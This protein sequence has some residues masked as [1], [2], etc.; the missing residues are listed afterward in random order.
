MKLDNTKQN[1]TFS[2]LYRCLIMI[3]AMTPEWASFISQRNSFKPC[4][5]AEQKVSA[6]N[7][8]ETNKRQRNSI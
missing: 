2:E 6:A 5:C 4:N 3:A 1:K 8:G 7:F